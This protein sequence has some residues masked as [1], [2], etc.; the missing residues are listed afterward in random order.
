MVDRRKLIA[1]ASGAAIWPLAVRSQERALPLIGWL[2]SGAPTPRDLASFERA[3]NEFGFVI[4]RNVT[5]AYRA[6]Q[7]SNVRLSEL[8]A[9]LVGR[10]ASVLV[11]PS[12]SPA[13]AAKAVTATVPIVFAVGGDAVK[14]RLIASYERPGGNATGVNVVDSS[15]ESK[16][17]ALLH[18][19]VPRAAPIAAILNPANAN[20]DDALRDLEQGA[21]AIRAQILVLSASTVA[22]IDT[23]FDA[24]VERGARAAMIT[25]D[26]FL[27]GQRAR[28]VALAAR[29]SVP[30]MGTRRDFA[31]AGGLISF[32]PNS[33]D[34]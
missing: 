9:D 23:A 2:G 22:D 10:N 16:R 34:V 24:L 7:G 4:G 26:P 29:H 19:L 6:A 21:R 27:G 20:F 1:I 5:I 28:V 3:L 15:T 12:T 30:T 14:L 18:E 13:L 33:A 25:A 17:L 32:G 8:A 11:A 31:E